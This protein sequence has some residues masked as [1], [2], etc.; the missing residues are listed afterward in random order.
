MEGGNNV[1]EILSNLM[2]NYCECTLCK[3]LLPELC[4][5]KNEKVSFLLLKKLKPCHC[6][7]FCD[8]WMAVLCMFKKFY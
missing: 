3:T 8:V 1:D 5:T 7:G 4:I 2:L 6:G